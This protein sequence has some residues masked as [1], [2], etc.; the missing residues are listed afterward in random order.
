MAAKKSRMVK[1]TYASE[2]W[3]DY[4]E[5]N[6]NMATLYIKDLVRRHWQKVWVNYYPGKQSEDGPKGAS[7]YINYNPDE[8]PE[9]GSLEEEIHDD[10]YT[11]SFEDIENHQLSSEYTEIFYI[12]KLGKRKYIH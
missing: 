2:I 3:D 4:L 7:L 8:H 9:S 11:T 6:N 5:S 1:I 12:K 10:K